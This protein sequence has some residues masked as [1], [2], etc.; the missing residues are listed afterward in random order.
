VWQWWR[1]AL[2]QSQEASVEPMLWVR[3]RAERAPSEVTK[4]FGKLPPVWL[5]MIRRELQT[6][7]WEK[8]PYPD[9]VW[10]HL[11]V[12]YGGV[13]PVG[14]MSWRFLNVNPRVFLP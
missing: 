2:T 1:Q 5:V 6:R 3:R 4:E 9:L 10:E 11:D 14:Y 13:L 7:I 8:L 12:D